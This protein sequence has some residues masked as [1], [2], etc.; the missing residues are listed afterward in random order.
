MLDKSAAED[1]DAVVVTKETAD[2]LSLKSIAD[3]EGKSEQ[4]VLGG[5]PEWKTRPTGI[6]GSRRCTAWSSSSSAR[7]TP[8]A[9]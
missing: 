2:K 1:K 6:P 8:A 4:L 3:L 5:P 7:S 9:R